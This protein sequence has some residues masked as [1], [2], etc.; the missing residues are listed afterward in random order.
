MDRPHPTSGLSQCEYYTLQYALHLLSRRTTWPLGCEY[1]AW[2]PTQ[3]AAAMEE[4]LQALPHLADDTQVAHKVG[5]GGWGLGAAQ[6][7]GPCRGCCAAGLPGSGGPPFRAG[8]RS[9]WVHQPKPVVA[10]NAGVK[11]PG[12]PAA[13]AAC[14]SL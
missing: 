3:G 6:G 13:A 5:A 7:L 4:A 1:L 14:T 12:V 10:Q 2:C 11:V 9:G 8:G